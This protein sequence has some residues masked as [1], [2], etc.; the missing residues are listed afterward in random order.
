MIVI[1]IVVGAVVM[2]VAISLP[3]LAFFGM[4]GCMI[5]FGGH[6]AGTM[7]QRIYHRGGP[8]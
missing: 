8:Q 4:L 5:R 6:S 1:V 2:L 7:R 3:D